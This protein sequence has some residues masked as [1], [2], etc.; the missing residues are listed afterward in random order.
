M[1]DPEIRRALHAHLRSALPGALVTDELGILR[2]RVFADVI[3]VDDLLHGFEIKAACDSLS[4]LP[5][6]IAAY[7]RVFDRCAL[8]TEPSHLRAVLGMLPAWWGVTVMVDGVPR[9]ERLAAPNE[10]VEPL[11]V[12]TLLWMEDVTD[13]LAERRA[14]RGYRGKPMH[15][16]W[17]RMCDVFTGDEIRAAVRDVVRLRRGPPMVE[18]VAPCS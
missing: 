7:S 15:E 6:Q 16:L 4:R 5:G 1:N 3:A 11:A 18:E 8:V 9:E 13:M 10:G 14:L 2:G 17:A 12:A